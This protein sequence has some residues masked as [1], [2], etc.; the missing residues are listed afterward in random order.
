MHEG[1]QEKQKK[2]FNDILRLKM[3]DCEDEFRHK[4]YHVVHVVRLSSLFLSML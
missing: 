3:P 1:D 4:F 2:I